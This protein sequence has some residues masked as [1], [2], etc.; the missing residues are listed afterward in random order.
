MIPKGWER[1]LLSSLIEALDAGVSVNS[2]DRPKETGEIGILKTSAVTYG[3]F[4]PHAHKTIL[5][6]EEKRAKLNPVKG[7]IIISRMNTKALVGASVYIAQ[8]Y[9]NLF[10]PD[11]LWQTRRKHDSFSMHW[12]SYL[13]A[14]D[15]MRYRISSVARGTSGSMK[16]ISKKDL[17]SLKI[18]IPPLL[19]QQKIAKILS[20]W[21]EA[22]RLT[23]ELVAAKEQRKKGLM[24]RLLTGQ[25]RFDGF[26]ERLGYRNAL[27]MRIPNHWIW[28]L[29][30]EE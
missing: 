6:D 24:Q 14:S 16:N 13:L 30:R 11:R 22:I 9:K 28:Q 20:T 21:D 19:E 27:N 17:L 1:A 29:C 23:Q 5:R 8:D 10:L 7:S 25:V 12:L 18:I 4:D 15:H 2:E 3:V 26:G